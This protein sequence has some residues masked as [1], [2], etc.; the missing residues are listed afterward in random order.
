MTDT[1]T[2]PPAAAG[3]VRRP[4]DGRIAKI[5]ITGDGVNGGVLEVWDVKGLDRGT[6]NNVNSAGDTMT[7][8]YLVANGT[9][10]HKINVP[11]TG[12]EVFTLGAGEGMPFN[13]GLAVRFVA[14][15]GAVFVAPFIEGGFGVQE[16]PAG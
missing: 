4:R 13:K 5:E 16:V 12:G 10:I 7:N 9:L 11:A 15:S 14:S 8:V 6:T 1:G 2:W 3:K